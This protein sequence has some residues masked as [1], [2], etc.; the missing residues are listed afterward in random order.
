LLSTIPLLLGA[1]QQTRR[2]VLGE[3]GDASTTGVGLSGPP[4][5]YYDRYAK[6]NMRF[7]TDY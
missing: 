3:K 7:V 2:G 5:F 1:E 6:S 4:S